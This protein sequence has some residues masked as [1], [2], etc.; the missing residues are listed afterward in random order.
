MTIPIP[1]VKLDA[2]DAEV[3]R[4]KAKTADASAPLPKG[5]DSVAAA[6]PGVIARLERLKAK[7][8]AFGNSIR[9]QFNA[10]AESIPCGEHPEVRR[11]KDWDATFEQSHGHQ[12]FRPMYARCPACVTE[13]ANA[14]LRRFWA[15]R[16]VPERLLE[17]TFTNFEQP[18]EAHSQARNLAGAC[19][20]RELLFLILLGDNGN[21]KSHLGAAALKA[22]GDGLFIEHHSLIAE[23]RASYGT[24]TTPDIIERYQDAELLVLDEVGFST[25]GADEPVHLHDILSKRHDC[26]RPTILTSNEELPKLKEI[27]GF[28][29]MDRM[30]ESYEIKVLRGQSFRRKP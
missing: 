8:E 30:A 12:D 24:K 2:L 7:A 10:L 17:S 25:G 16:G 20:R 13:D 9:P 21:G 23:I 15:R 14:R 5:V 6:M 4:R 1:T 26:R 19:A 28:R 18:T 22:C 29:L 11:Q 27:L 3:E